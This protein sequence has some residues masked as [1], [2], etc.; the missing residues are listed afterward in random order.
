MSGTPPLEKD[1]HDERGQTSAE[2]VAIVTKVAN[3]PISTDTRFVMFP[4]LYDRLRD[5]RADVR[6][7]REQ[8]RTAL[9]EDDRRGQ[10]KPRVRPSP[11]R[12][13]RRPTS[14]HTRLH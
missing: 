5:Y 8:L 7:S 3:T 9:T 13:T 11:S 6:R 12:G 4:H 10:E 2:R 1:P 14:V